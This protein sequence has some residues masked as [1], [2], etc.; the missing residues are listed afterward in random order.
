MASVNCCTVSFWIHG[1]DAVHKVV[2][3]VY[4]TVYAVRKVVCAVQKV[5][6]GVDE[7]KKIVF[8]ILLKESGIF[9]NL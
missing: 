5:W 6:G 2:H 7:I 8:S 1:V 3:R 4:N 9:F